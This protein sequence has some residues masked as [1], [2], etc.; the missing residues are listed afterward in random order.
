MRKR[1]VLMVV[2]AAVLLVLLGSLAGGEFLS[3]G[4]KAIPELAGPGLK[5]AAEGA[6]EQEGAAAL[7]VPAP[8]S[9]DT[10]EMIV[11][12]AEDSG[13]I[14]RGMPVPGFEDV[15]EMIVVEE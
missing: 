8:G 9:E 13:P 11:V 5:G 15:P 12:G 1:F 14:S 2:A 4:D 3:A 10:P 7:G 6:G